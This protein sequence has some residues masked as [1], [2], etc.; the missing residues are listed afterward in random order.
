MP[1]GATGILAPEPTP[2]TGRIPLKNLGKAA[3]VLGALGEGEKPKLDPLTEAGSGSVQ[4]KQKALL[5]E[6][7]EKLNTLF[8]GELTP[9]DKL[10]YVG[11]VLLGKML[12]SALLAQQASGN[13]A[14]Q[15]AGS[16]DIDAALS[17]ALIEALDAHTHMSTQALNS[18]EVRRGTKDLLLTQFGLWE[19]LRA[20]AG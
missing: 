15:F 5:N 10:V 12:E 2:L 18:A 9:D 11:N 19:R 16:P 13:T 7:I 14:E 6:I 1:I 4:E 17:N 8:E 3:L 20:K